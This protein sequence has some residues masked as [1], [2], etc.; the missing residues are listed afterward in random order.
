M[1]FLKLP[2]SI[3]LSLIFVTLLAASAPART[4]A[5]QKRQTPAKPQPQ[6]APVAPAP[7]TPTPPP[8][9]DTLL[10]A[11]LYRI[12]GEV[13]SVGQLIRSNSISEILEP[14][15]KLAGPPKEFRNVVKWL[16]LHADE[17]MTSRMLVAVSPNGS[18]VPRT[19]VAIEF[20]STEEATKFQQKLNEF[21][22]KVL[23]PESKTAGNTQPAAQTQTQSEP[24]YYI[25]QAGSLILVTSTKLDLK[26]LRPAGSKLLAE[27]ANFR[28]A[29]NRF[30]SES[31]FIYV[32]VDGIEREEQERNKDLLALTAGVTPVDVKTE[33]RKELA[34]PETPVTPEM[35]PPPET[36]PSGV[37]LPPGVKVVASNESR[38]GEVVGVAVDGVPTEP[39]PTIMALVS[40]GSAFTSGQARWPA[41]LGIAISL[42]G[43]SFDVRALMINSPGEKSDPIPFFPV[44]TPGPSIALGSPSILP[45]D[46]EMLISMSLDFSQIYATLT[47]PPSVAELIARGVPPTKVAEFESPYASIE[48]QLKIKLKDD[49]VP[50]LGSEIVVSLPITGLDFIQPPSGPD[51]AQT[52]TQAQP[53]PKADTKEPAKDEPKTTRSP[54]AAISLRDKEGMRA[55]LPKIIESVAFKGANA[56]AQTERRGDTEIVSYANMLSYAFIG[57]FLV[58][59]PDAATTRHVVDSYLKG[60][61][62]ASEP[63]FKNYTRWQPRQV[64]GQ[65]YI[66]PALMESYKKWV[67]EPDPKMDDQ[68]RAFLARLSIVPQPVTYSLYNE[69]FGPVHEL[70]L[71]KNLVLMFIAGISGSVN[72][73]TNPPTPGKGP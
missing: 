35:P 48:K 65:L 71:P 11:D 26:K 27:D 10:S 32:D 14:I 68:T 64:Q 21:L 41:G 17:V 56:F 38:T 45:A 42:D 63:N 43:E 31:I 20:A 46:T 6:K 15:L 3:V 67:N 51:P 54:V 39:N 36:L 60:E 33:E 59:S 57:D 34:E 73:L 22:P 30:N 29:R 72:Q 55:L 44:L 4:V 2:A 9:F 18:Q 25:Q 66:S 61:T 37:T 28:V 1:K 70:H 53:Q 40:L 16:N 7:A 58:A 8:S 50:L 69:G 49:L 19:L 52:Q 23:P 62:L 47:K 24:Q 12:Y 13:R 5:Q